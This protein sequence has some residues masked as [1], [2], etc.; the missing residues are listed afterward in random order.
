MGPHPDN[1]IILSALSTVRARG[2]GRGQCVWHR[3]IRD[4]DAAKV[5]GGEQGRV[6]HVPAASGHQQWHAGEWRDR[7]PEACLWH[8]GQHSER[9]QPDGL[10]GRDMEN[11]SARLHGQFAP[12]KGLHVLGRWMVKARKGSADYFR[13]FRSNFRSAVKSAWKERASWGR[14]GSWAREITLSRRR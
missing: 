9:G 5:A 14:I 1:S 2:H 3:R 10:D 4:C 8:L 7:G 12:A 13:N 11:P 6:Q